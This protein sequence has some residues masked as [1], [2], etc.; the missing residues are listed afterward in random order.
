MVDKKQIMKLL[1]DNFSYTGTVS[2][3]D[4]GLVSCTGSVS[5]TKNVSVLPVKFSRVDGNF[6]C[7]NS[8]LSTLEG[9]PATVGGDFNCNSNPN[10]TTLK[11]APTRVDGRFRCD[12]SPITTLEGAPTFVGDGFWC[13]GTRLTT[14]EHSPT[15]VVGNFWC[16]GSILTT[17][18]GAPTSIGGGF[19]CSNNQ[20][21]SLEHAPATV[22][23]DFVCSNNRLTTLEGLPT[24]LKLLQISYSPN[25]PLL[26]TLN[27]QTIRFDPQLDDP[28]VGEILGRYTGQGEAGAFPCG[29]ELATAGYKE[30]ARW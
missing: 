8:Q 9:A 28:T 12:Y 24:Q 22:G 26:R 6:F 4:N 23:G 11:G 16:Y 19:L 18:Q 10:L 2:V 25:L 30:N 15:T 27:A 5:V 7:S 13:Y 1:K 21:T 20:L 17:L 3:D 14:L 29:A